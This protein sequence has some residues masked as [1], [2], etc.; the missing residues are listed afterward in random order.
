MSKE[1]FVREEKQNDIYTDK[2]W[3]AKWQKIFKKNTASIISE[4]QKSQKL[5]KRM[6][7]YHYPK[8]SE[9]SDYNMECNVEIEN[10][11]EVFCKSESN[12]MLFT[13]YYRQAL[14]LG[15]LTLKNKIDNQNS[16]TSLIYGDFLRILFRE[17]EAVSVRNII[18][19]L[20]VCKDEGLLQGSNPVEEY[21][22]YQ[23]HYLEDHE[24]RK[25]L[26]EKYPVMD[27]CI[28]K[29][30]DKVTDNV[31]TVIKN[32]THDL[33][34]IQEK[35]LKSKSAGKLQK[36]NGGI[37][38]THKGGKNVLEL[39]LDTGMRIIYKPH[40]V[41]NEVEFQ[42]WIKFYSSKLN[43]TYYQPVIIEKDGYG[44][45]ECVSYK[46][47]SKA[48]EISRFYYR[49]GISL[50]IAYVFQTNDL[51]F[52]NIIVHG[53]NPVFVDIEAITK[54]RNNMSDMS[55]N[56]KIQ[57][58]IKESVMA[59][60]I[61]PSYHWHNSLGTGVDVSAMGQEEYQK[62]PIKIPVVSHPFTS[63]ICI[64]YRYGEIRG[65]KNI[66]RLDGEK[67]T[68]EKYTKEVMQGFKD[69]YQYAVHHKQ[70]L[71]SEVIKEGNLISRYLLNDTQKYS[72]V[73][74]GSYHPSLMMDEADREMYMHVLWN[75]NDELTSKRKVILQCEIED[76][77][78]GDIPCFEVRLCDRE[79]YWHDK[80]IIHEYLPES[81]LDGILRK[82]D[83][84]DL[85]D[86]EQ[87]LTF[88][89]LAMNMKAHKKNTEFADSETESTK[90]QIVSSLAERMIQTA[91][92]DKYGHVNWMNY[93]WDKHGQQG[94]RAKP[95]GIY[96]YD[97]LAG[98]AIVFQMLLQSRK[99]PEVY[100]RTFDMVVQQ[101][102]EYTETVSTDLKKAES[103]NSGLYNGEASVM[104]AYLLLYQLTDD[105]AYLQLGKKH[106][107]IVQEIA[108]KDSGAD[109]LDGKAGA[110]KG[111]LQ[112]YEICKEKKYLVWAEK[113]EEKLADEAI[114][115]NQ[116]MAW[117]P[118]DMEHPL[119]GMAHGNAGISE[120][121]RMLYACTG[122]EDYYNKLEKVVR[123]EHN[124]FDKETGEWNDYRNPQNPKVSKNVPIAWCH[125]SG[126][127]L[128]SRLR[129]KKM[130]LNPV[131]EQMVNEDIKRALRKIEKN[132]AREERCLC[133]GMCGN[134]IILEAGRADLCN[135]DSKRSGIALE[136]DTMFQKHYMNVTNIQEKYNI[137]MMSGF[138]GVLGFSVCNL[139][140][141]HDIL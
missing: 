112:L 72:M 121:Y 85:Q 30:I 32:F 105:K 77:L 20:H 33:P 70:E 24:Y 74:T 129:L 141:E 67:V 92:Y 57:E 19:E 106:A 111:L 27:S 98:I 132:Y 95:C 135:I 140:T 35:I 115:T 53:E 22:Y 7:Y 4:V 103:T 109:L 119:L 10:Y 93:I 5:S 88:I 127:I 28:F 46:V 14:Y 1:Y 2:I 18:H 3:Y 59:T 41:K 23:D 126:G 38:D 36:I 71:K 99:M 124:R 96:F 75:E 97:G 79:L 43:L 40:S 50:F 47:C 78:Q 13:S 21:E 17:L 123:Y 116:E 25:L 110:I 80:A 122:F 69:A 86:R 107:G 56:E 61:L 58:I 60:G 118:V 62:M 120:A 114:K 52:E 108:M 49:M 63:D 113:I 31:T 68:A 9:I 34:E 64:T 42:K 54:C 84:L 16:Y 134:K 81:P 101:L 94:W 102:Q 6:G 89:D 37:A 133:H 51:H 90:E 137:G 87:Q 130:Q 26:S 39:I 139:I 136:D 83:G 125:G 8:Y 44:W 12:K 128:L 66:V 117:K 91:F 15:T 138:G 76:L 100:H 29:T 65:D 104:W 73:L 82:I 11:V 131:L 48:E 55:A 45:E